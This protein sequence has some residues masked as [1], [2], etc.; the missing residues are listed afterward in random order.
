MYATAGWDVWRHT[1]AQCSVTFLS[2][3]YC[4]T[5]YYTTLIVARL[6]RLSSNVPDQEIIQ[7]NQ[8]LLS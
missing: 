7:V 3:L 5:F 8:I 2:D 1:L 6:S 4:V